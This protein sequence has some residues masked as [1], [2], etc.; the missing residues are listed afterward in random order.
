MG[1]WCRINQSKLRHLNH[2]L[3]RC[4]LQ[5]PSPNYIAAH[6]VENPFSSVVKRP[7]HFCNNVRF[8]AAPIQY[9]KK[10]EKDTNETRLNNQITAP[11]VRLVMEEGHRVVSRH[12]ALEL[13][14]EL[15]LDLVEVQ[16]NATP[17]V[18]KIMDFHKEKYKKELSEKDR[19][20][21]KSDLTL[22]KGDCK[23][24]RFSGKIEKKDLQMKA[25]SV[26]RLMER[27]YRVKCMALPVSKKEEQ[28]EDLGGYLS[29]L[30]VLIED[31]AIVESGPH[32]EKK[33]AYA[34]TRHVKF[35]PSKKG[36]AKKLKALGD[37]SSVVHKASTSSPTIDP[38]LENEDQTFD[39]EVDLPMSP[40]TEMQNFN[41]SFYLQDDRR[42][43]TPR[44]KLPSPPPETSQGAENRYKQSEPRNQFPPNRPR[45]N[46]GPGM[47]DSVRSGPPQFP[48][49]R[50][51]PP[52]PNMNDSV[53]SV[54]PQFPNQRRQPP[55]PNMNVAPSTGEKKQ[56]GTDAS[57]LSNTKP[58]NNIPKQEQSR[59][60][61]GI[62]ST[63]KAN[64]P[65]NFHR[66]GEGSPHTSARNPGS[67]GV[68][69]NR[70]IPGPKSDGSQSS[71]T[72]LT[73]CVS[74][75]LLLLCRRGTL[76]HS[77]FP[78]A[79][80]KVLLRGILLS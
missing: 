51:Q 17:P 79:I 40:P 36:G 76:S 73:L 38:G 64:A 4:F 71:G 61:F 35:G 19:A 8:F 7:T 21:A 67:A 2:Q 46:R 16:R 37:A 70:N 27:G 62:F 52:P 72:A 68:G 44:D 58:P 29:R 22:K 80:I 25:D 39:D 15:K 32:V 59:P 30:L 54:P 66:N 23:E 57:V 75:L 14:S 11:F 42:G 24:V 31:I 28:E 9:Q 60:G 5:A 10:E 74:L 63:P 49:Q 77:R 34:I 56:A 13:A 48:N 1:F 65:A 43:A 55:P 26:K 18:C 50:R 3:K 41:N 33:Q 69:A 78:A 45:D 20:K 53:R 12:E 6:L 47:S